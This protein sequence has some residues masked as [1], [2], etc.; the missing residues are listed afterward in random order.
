[1]RIWQFII[2]IH[3]FAEARFDLVPF[4]V[5]VVV[6]ATVQIG[7][8]KDNH[9]TGF[10]ATMMEIKIRK[11]REHDILMKMFPP[12][13]VFQCPDLYINDHGDLVL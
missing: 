12:E 10:R 11:R 7:S 13:R 9:E 2:C 6:M 1:M 8:N 3:T 5:P 4:H